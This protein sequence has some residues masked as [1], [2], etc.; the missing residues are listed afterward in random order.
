MLHLRFLMWNMVQFNDT[1][2]WNRKDVSLFERLPLGSEVCFKIHLSIFQPL[3]GDLGSFHW[4]WTIF[5]LQKCWNFTLQGQNVLFLLVQV[6]FFL[7]SFLRAESCF[8][9]VLETFFVLQRGKKAGL[10]RKTN[11]GTQVWD[12]QIL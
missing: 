11:D 2:R 12:F 7:E 4:G 10:H 3:G 8:R 6:K 1:W 9:S 5:F